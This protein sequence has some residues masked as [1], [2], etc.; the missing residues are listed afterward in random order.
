MVASAG[1]AERCNT[2]IVSEIVV[3]RR[4]RHARESRAPTLHDVARA[5]GV[6]TASVSRALS[7]PELVSQIVHDRVRIAIDTLAYVP[8]A[9]ARA[10]SG[11]SARVVGAVVTTLHDPVTLLALEALTRE[12]AT[13][14]V[15]L[16]LSMAGEGA[17]SSAA[18]ARA[19]VAQG[20]D[21]I[22]FGAGATPPE[23]SR[24]FV[25]RKVPYA[26]LDETV[27]GA[28]QVTSGFDR[29]SALV[30]AGRYLR[31]LGHRRIGLFALA[32]ERCASVVRDA[33][34]GAGIDVVGDLSQTP[35]ATGSGVREVLDDWL[36]A[37]A[38]PTAAI[39]GSD[40]AA[41]AMLHECQRR[42]TVVPGQWSIIGLGDTELSRQVRP[43]LTTLR[44]PARAAGS[45]IARSL[46]AELDGRAEAPVS[47]TAKIVARES[48][49][50]PPGK[51][52]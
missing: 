47:L 4:R 36:Q 31:Q 16:V 24:L 15:A 39:C 1:L 42:G 37:A 27:A 43:T 41:V 35:S 21:A 30:L 19:L 33:L 10:L 51:N 14:G 17:T 26:C 52:R 49:G 12:L 50:A 32:S 25:G 23:P 11:R 29:A 20:V 7:R 13:G 8:N 22:V 45:A 18:C 44:V 5:A 34:A 3:A 46:L 6:S 40:I 48:T 2:C 28:A 9:A 38:R